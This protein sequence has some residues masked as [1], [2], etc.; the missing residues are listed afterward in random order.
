MSKNYDGRVFLSQ[1]EIRTIINALSVAA[2]QRLKNLVTT[3]FMS[4]QILESVEP[5]EK[6]IVKLNSYSQKLKGE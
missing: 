3:P 1:A 6:L 5:E 4:T 2:K